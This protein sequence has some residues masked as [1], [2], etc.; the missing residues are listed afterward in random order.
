MIDARAPKIGAGKSEG[1]GIFFGDDTH[2]A[3]AVDE[4]AV[5]GHQLIHIIKSGREGCQEILEHRQ[6]GRRKITGLTAHPSVAGRESGT[7]ELLD[8]VVDF[9]TLGE[10]V[11]KEGC[12]TEIHAETP[13]GQEVG[14]N[15]GEFAT[16]DANRFATGRQFPAHEFLN[17]EGVGDVVRDGER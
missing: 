4:N 14:G 16:N 8:H 5:A 11:E 10:S 12:R 3:A 1:D 13:S 7:R 15:A 9:L 2:I 6:E 17:S